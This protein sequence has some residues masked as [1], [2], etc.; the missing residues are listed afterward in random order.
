M[1]GQDAIQGIRRKTK[2]GW[3]WVDGIQSRMRAA[4]L[5][6]Q[7]V[8]QSTSQHTPSVRERQEELLAFYQ[9]YEELVEVLCDAANYGPS[10]KLDSRYQEQ[11]AWMQRNY[12][13]VRRYVLA[14]L[15]LDS[16]DARLFGHSA[17]AFEALFFAPDLKAFLNADDG[18]MIERIMR[19]REALTLYGGHLRQLLEREKE[20]V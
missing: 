2:N 19:T 12:S 7:Q 8:K 14:Y 3:Q 1:T 11:R 18:N 15:R 13:S 20:C 10:P 9:H 17:D 16:S 5:D 6:R 4:A